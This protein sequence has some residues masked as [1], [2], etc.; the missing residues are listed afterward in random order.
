MPKQNS[1][2]INNQTT[3]VDD[4]FISFLKTEFKAI[5]VEKIE[6]VIKTPKAKT[7]KKVIVKKSE[8]KAG[9][10]TQP[11]P[12]LSELAFASKL[13]KS[14]EVFLDNEEKGGD[15]FR[16]SFSN[17]WAKEYSKKQADLLKEAQNI[18]SARPRTKKESVN[19]LV[20]FEDARV[21]WTAI[22]LLL[23]NISVYSVLFCP[24]TTKLL[25]ASIQNPINRTVNKVAKLFIINPQGDGFVT[26]TAVID[27]P[28]KKTVVDKKLF[29]NYIKNNSDSIKEDQAVTEEDLNG[30][31]AGVSE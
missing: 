5:K 18:I 15:V 11:R 10:P 6:E 23:L 7:T 13:S 17:D 21:R 4:R 22:A 28:R 12:R 30:Q 1:D 26:D 24:T 2:Q 9:A 31:V 25:I 14:V 19:Y 27:S 16:N 3:V 29:S 8:Q 20:V